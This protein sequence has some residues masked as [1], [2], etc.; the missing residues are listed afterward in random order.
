MTLGALLEAG[1]TDLEKFEVGANLLV[2]SA[3]AGNIPIADVLVAPNQY[4]A[5][6][7][8]MGRVPKAKPYTAEELNATPNFVKLGLMLRVSPKKART[9][10]Y[11]HRNQFTSQIKSEG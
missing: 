10:Y 4:E 5:I 8:P 2:R 7:N 11:F 1:T 6:F 3:A 9:L